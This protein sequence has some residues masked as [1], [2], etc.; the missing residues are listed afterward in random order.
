MHNF[1]ELKRKEKKCKL[2]KNV[3]GAKTVKK[4]KIFYYEVTILYQQGVALT[5]RNTI[6]PPSCADL[7][8]I[9]ECYRRRQQ[10]TPATVTG[11]AHYTMHRWASNK[12]TTSSTTVTAIH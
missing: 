3:T 1:D 6:G 10:T 12:T 4:S 9:C 5:G 7:R 11:L 8:C 2:I